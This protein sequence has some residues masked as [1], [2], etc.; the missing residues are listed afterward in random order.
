[1]NGGAGNDTLDGGTGVD[2]LSGGAGDDTFHVDDAADFV[3]EAAGAGTD[4]VV[5]TANSHNLRVNVENLSFAGTGN[6]TG[7]GNGLANTIS[8]GDGNDTLNGGGNADTMAGGGGNDLY[9][10]E[11]AGDVVIELDGGGTDTVRTT[12]ASRTL[13]SNVENLTYVGGGSFS[14]TGNGLENVITGNGGNDTLNGLVGNDTLVGAG[15]SD[16]LDGGTGDD[17]MAGGEG[18]D[19]Y[20]VDSA[21]DVVLENAGLGSD[22]VNTTLNSYTL[23]GTNIENLAFTGTGNFSGSGNSF[24]NNIAGGDAGDV[25]LGAGGNDT[26]TGG[27]GNDFLNGGGGNDVFVFGAAGFGSDTIQGFDSNPAGGQDL[28]DISG[29]GVTAASFAGQVSLTDLGADTLIT[30]GG[31]SILLLGIGNPAAIDASDFLL[32]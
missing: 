28:L 19:T 32:A 7:V 9:V 3:L 31:D 5:S 16:T 15:G 25:L 11:N 13:G 27:A 17:R 23:A 2:T 30:I 20:H 22:T 10:V 4:T 24:A 12:L 29:L 1:V 6:F 18:D 21:A 14:G 8:G 26:L